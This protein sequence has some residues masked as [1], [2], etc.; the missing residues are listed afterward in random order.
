MTKQMKGIFD[1]RKD[2]Y[3]MISCVFM[4]GKATRVV[5]E[6][7]K[8]LSHSYK[9]MKLFEKLELGIGSWRENTRVLRFVK[10][11]ISINDYIS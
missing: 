10:K 7:R 2:L 6:R 9:L 1:V 4:C 8:V 11:S 3:V 5:C